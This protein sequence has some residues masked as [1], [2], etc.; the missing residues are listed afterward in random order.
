MILNTQSYM[1]D[2]LGWDWKSFRAPD[3]ANDLLAQ[4]PFLLC[5]WLGGLYDMMP[6]VEGQSFCG[7]SIYCLSSQ[8]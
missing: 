5:S 2:G 1:L 8:S 7:A 4:G 3:G 6:F